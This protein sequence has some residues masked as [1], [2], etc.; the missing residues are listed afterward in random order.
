MALWPRVWGR[1]EP[2][3]RG[4]VDPQKVAPVTEGGGVGARNQAVPEPTLFLCLEYKALHN[5]TPS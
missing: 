2:V 5:L 4:L 3:A 1:A